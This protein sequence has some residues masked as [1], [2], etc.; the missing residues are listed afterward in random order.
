MPRNEILLPEEAATAETELKKQIAGA[1]S[2]IADTV[3]RL[4]ERYGTKETPQAVT[5][6]IKQ[7][8]IQW[9]KVLRIADVL[10]Y[11]VVWRKRDDK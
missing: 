3:R 10:G 6:Q 2:N 11:E 9:W 1:G 5:R 4:N 7:G 8:T